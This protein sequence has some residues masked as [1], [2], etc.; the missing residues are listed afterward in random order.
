MQ[1]GTAK[2]QKQEG[3]IVP[4]CVLLAVPV[5]DVAAKSDYSIY[6]Y[7]IF[8]IIIENYCYISYNI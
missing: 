1:R 6:V 4:I 7:F 2:A 8:I 3:R 5:A